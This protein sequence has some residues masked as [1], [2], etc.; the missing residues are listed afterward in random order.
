M[1]EIESIS[2]SS[3]SDSDTLSLDEE[4]ENWLSSI[5]NGLELTGLFLSLPAHKVSECFIRSVMTP[6]RPGKD[7]NSAYYAIELITRIFITTFSLLTS[8]LTI[9]LALVGAA[10]EK[11]GD[12]IKQTPYTHWK[13]KAIEKVEGEKRKLLTLNACMLWGGLPIPLGGMRSPNARIAELSKKILTENPDIIVM[14]EMAYDPSYRLYHQ[15]KDHYAHFF[16]RIGPNPP[17]MESGLFVASKY[18]VLN[19]GFIPFPGQLGINRGAFWIET[20][21][22]FV[23]TTHLE[24]G[25]EKTGREKRKAQLEL[26]MKQIEECKKQK[27]CYLMGDLNLDRSKTDEYFA[28]GIPEKFHDP[29]LAKYPKISEESSTCTNAIET[30]VLGK[31]PPQDPWE[32][33]DY[34][35][36]AKKEHDRI[37]LQVELMQ[38]YDDQEPYQAL[39]DH[40]GILLTAS[41]L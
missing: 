10:C 22:S 38:T 28:L 7:G 9:G 6:I 36:L 11:I 34:A 20:P 3:T 15:L 17:L 12:V 18:K 30:Y 14:Q 35:L 24:F 39:S 27:T 37:D 26:I 25:D 8:P 19:A 2:S 1:S 40:R 29:Y 16:V 41:S 13:G 23:F 33:D 21:N 32:L 5:A 31:S 4:E